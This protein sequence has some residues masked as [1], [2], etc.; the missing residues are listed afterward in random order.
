MSLDGGRIND[1]TTPEPRATH[2]TEMTETTRRFL[3]A[4][5]GETIDQAVLDD[6]LAASDIGKHIRFAGDATEIIVPGTA[7][8]GESFACVITNIRAA[9]NV[10]L[11]PGSGVELNED[12]AAILVPQY[13]S[14]IIEATG[15]DAYSVTFR[16]NEVS[17]AMGFTEYLAKLSQAATDAPVPEVLKND[18]GVTPTWSRTDVGEYQTDTVFPGSGL[19]VQATLALIGGGAL[20]GSPI[21]YDD[22]GRIKLVISKPDGTSL[23][24][25]VGE[26]FISVKIIT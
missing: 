25:L 24:D 5:N 20:K 23:Q 4:I 14:A 16:V 13:C 1:P 10:T 22:A 7:I 18:T 15:E 11:T 12:T 9:G 21:A 8:L 19:F 26:L 3:A 17:G 2:F 6:E